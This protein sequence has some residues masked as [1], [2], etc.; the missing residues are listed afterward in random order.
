[1]GKKKDPHASALVRKRWSKTTKAERQAFGQ[2]LRDCKAR[3]CAEREK[4]RSG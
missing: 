4:R 3:K 2:M 1:M